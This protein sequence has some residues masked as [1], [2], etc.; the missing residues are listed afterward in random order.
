M[1]YSVSIALLASLLAVQAWADE[2]ICI[3][4][5]TIIDVEQGAHK[6]RHNL[7]IRYDRIETVTDK[8]LEEFECDTLIDGR[9]KFV[10]PGLWDMHVHGTRRTHLWPIYIANGVTGMRDL[11]GPED[12]EEL[13]NQLSDASLKPRVNISGPIVDGPPG[14]WP[15]SALVAN[16]EEARR[17]VREQANAGADFIKVYQLLSRDA[18]F[19][20]I[21]EAMKAGLP[22]AGH[23]PS[24]LTAMEVSEAGQATIEHLGD[25][26]VSC[27]GDEQA[28]RAN[29]P[30]SFVENRQQEVEAFR[31]FDEKKC[32]R[33]AQHFLS[34]GTWLTPT[35]AV[36]HAESREKVG[37]ARDLELL[38]YFDADTQSWLHPDQSYPDEVRAILRE[39][40]KVHMQLVQFF[41]REG[42][43]ILAGTDV[44]NPYTFPGFAIHDELALLVDAGLSPLEALQ[45]ATI[46]AARFLGREAELGSVEV[47]KLADLVLLEADPLVDI[48]N[49]TTISGVF[50]NGTFYDASTLKNLIDPT[51]QAS[52]CGV[53]QFDG[54]MASGLVT[55]TVEMKEQFIA[56]LPESD[57]G[58]PYCWYQTDD[59]RVELTVGD[60][61]HFFVFD[62]E[63]WIYDEKQTYLIM[64][65]EKRSDEE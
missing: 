21:D 10:I 32:R 8:P 37:T 60:F 23:V 57:R 31:S 17:E 53:P 1:N 55:P 30:R 54:E 6:P 63:N 61:G 29:V 7:I 5:A 65:H 51:G 62:G 56:Q 59:G 2:Q 18:Y 22:V 33:L 58:W 9:G 36:S 46:N 4:G 11:F 15:G 42:V 28:L 35:L 40:L 24:A 3:G 49:S 16:V 34:N 50:S 13:R 39:A 26:A 25:L 43:P 14:F 19:A 38:N 20:I 12:T 48:G 64:W 27:A 52:D 47:G 44:M 45:A 41:H